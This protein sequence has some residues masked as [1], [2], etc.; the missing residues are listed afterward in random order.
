M[1]QSGEHYDIT[2]RNA[3]IAKIK[4][5][6]CQSHLNLAVVFI[7]IFLSQATSEDT[8]G[9][10]CFGKGIGSCYKRVSF[11]NINV[12]LSSNPVG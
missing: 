8:A 5:A 11:G 2:L 6:A 9:W 1:Q 4:M 7:L 3:G 10:V 12:L